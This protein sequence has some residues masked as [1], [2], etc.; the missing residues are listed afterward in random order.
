[1]VEITS[2]DNRI[3]FK[4]EK[5]LTG[6]YTEKLKEEL[7]K[8]LDKKVVEL[9]IDLSNV[10]LIDSTGLAVLVATHKSIR[11]KEGEF[12]LVNV[13]EAIFDLF[14]LTHLDRFFNLN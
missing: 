2:E 7:S 4:P 13:S 1:M 5:N 14:K 8:T 3:V 10:E 11:Q 6:E 12:K 9:V